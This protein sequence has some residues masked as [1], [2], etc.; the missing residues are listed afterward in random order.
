MKI[1]SAAAA[2]NVPRSILRWSRRVAQPKHDRCCS[3]LLAGS[4]TRVHR[5]HQSVAGAYHSSGF[6]SF[7]RDRQ[8]GSPP[9]PPHPTHVIQVLRID[10]CTSLL[11][12]PTRLPPLHELSA[13]G[14]VALRNLP[15]EVAGYLPEVLLT[16]VGLPVSMQ[17]IVTCDPTRPMR[18]MLLYR[19]TALTS[20]PEA[21]GLL[22]ALITIDLGGCSS[23]SVLPESVGGLP[24]LTHLNLSRCSSLSSIPHLWGCTKLEELDL[25]FCSSL[26]ALPEGLQELLDDHCLK[27]IRLGAL[28][29]P[30]NSF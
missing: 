8:S 13:V 14:C 6:S 10:A 3:L 11:A 15:S 25:S 9:Y 24:E 19:C 23:L 16:P 5:S 7:T 29:T 1:T 17:L 2:A 30:S 26:L 22:R 20:L 27:V 28:L 4:T 12:L 18:Q 21:I